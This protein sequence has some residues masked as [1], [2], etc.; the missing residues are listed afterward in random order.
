[1][2]SVQDLLAELRGMIMEIQTAA[3]TPGKIVTEEAESFVT[4]AETAIAELEQGGGMV[5]DIEAIGELTELAAEGAVIV[6]AL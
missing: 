4:R 1:M 3:Q 5:G 2:A 6:L